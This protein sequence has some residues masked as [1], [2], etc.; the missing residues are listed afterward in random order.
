[1]QDAKTETDPSGLVY[2]IGT[3]EEGMQWIGRETE[4]IE[5]PYPVDV[6][7]IEHFVEGIQDPNPLYWSDEFGRQTRWGGRIAPWGVVVLTTEHRVWRPDWMEKKDENATLFLR[8][9]LPGN[10]LLATDYAVECYVPLRPGDRVFVNEKLV[11][12][13]PKTFR[14]G[15]GHQV[16]VEKYF[17]NQE[18]ELCIKDSRTVFRYREGTG[19]GYKPRA[20]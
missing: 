10:R 12:I 2:V 8:T 3:V 16:T 1:M 5:E 17:R 4:P 19:A 15:E 6:E 7:H 13:V 18:R 20:Q 9:P 11:S 14:V